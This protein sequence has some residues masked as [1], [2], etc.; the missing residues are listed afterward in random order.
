MSRTPL[1]ACFETLRALSELRV[2]GGQE[3]GQGV[4]GSGNRPFSRGVTRSTEDRHT[5]AIES[6][7]IDS[8]HGHNAQV[9]AD[10]ATSS[11]SCYWPT[12]NPVHGVISYGDRTERVQKFGSPNDPLGGDTAN[13]SRRQSGSNRA[14]IF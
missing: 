13:R 2:T 11:T 7:D 5:N 3:R 8:W 12:D 9:R 4:A 10:S 1:S 6:V 14:K